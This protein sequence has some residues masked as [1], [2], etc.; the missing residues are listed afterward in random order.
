MQRSEPWIAAG[1]VLLMER[2]SSPQSLV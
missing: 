2:Y 1:R